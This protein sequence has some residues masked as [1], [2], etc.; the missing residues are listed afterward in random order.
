MK[1]QTTDKR[2]VLGV[3]YNEL[4]ECENKVIPNCIYRHFKGDLYLVEGIIFN[5]ERDDIDVLYRALYGGCTQYSRPLTEFLEELDEK[6]A[7]E[8][9]ASWRYTPIMINRN[10]EY[11][12]GD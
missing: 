8:Y 10:S 9:N 11:T 2:Y 12:E 6:R 5:V 1:Y 4:D 7:E 3:S